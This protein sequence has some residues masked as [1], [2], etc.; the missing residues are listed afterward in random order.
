MV[1]FFSF[2][3]KDSH[4]EMGFRVSKVN[5]EGDDLI[6]TR[7]CQGGRGNSLGKHRVGSEHNTSS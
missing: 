6:E 1:S 2:M 7:L 3:Y 4:G 5:A